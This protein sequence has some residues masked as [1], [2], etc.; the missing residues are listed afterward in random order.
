MISLSEEAAN[1]FKEKYEETY[2][3][4]IAESQEESV[5]EESDARNVSLRIRRSCRCVLHDGE[6]TDCGV[7]FVFWVQWKLL[8]ELGEL[9]EFSDSVILGGVVGHERVPVHLRMDRIACG[10]GEMSTR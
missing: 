9:A 8:C 6:S 4:D 7:R 10:F 3:N 2:A 5:D 1:A